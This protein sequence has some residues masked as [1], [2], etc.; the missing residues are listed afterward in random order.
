MKKTF[1]ELIIGGIKPGEIWEN[2]TQR[3]SRIYLNEYGNLQLEGEDNSFAQNYSTSIGLNATYELQRKEYTF[4]EAF[5]AYEEGREIES[6]C[7]KYKYKKV[8]GK[9]FASLEFGWDGFEFLEICE[10]R[11]SW[12][13][14]D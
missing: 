4:A 6:K 1:R 10:I 8:D 9:D 3:I 5:M 13:I 11:G 14:N 12:Y 7:S 2:K